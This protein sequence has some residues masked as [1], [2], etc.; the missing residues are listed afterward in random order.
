MTLP[1]V[2]RDFS[3][4]RRGRPAYAVWALDVDVPALRTRSADYC[5]HLA[6]VLL[7]G[8]VRQPHVTIG[9]CGFPVARP[10]WPDDYG[11]EDWL[12]QLDALAGSAPPPFVIE[13]GE[14]DSFTS[15]GY[16]PVVDGVGGID[17]LRALLT[18]VTDDLSYL[19]HVTFGLYRHVMPLNDVLA[20]LAGVAAHP[21]LHLEISRLS[22]M[23]YE[24]A[25]IGG[26]LTRLADFDLAE[27]RLHIREP[28][29]L[30]EL[31]GTAWPPPGF[32]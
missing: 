6:D 7:P 16:F 19:A 4:W 29:R 8:Y 30:R 9:L 3:E 5:A 31:F 21:P 28:A 23:T 14:P 27:R 15:A 12:A 18:P 32:A 26:P 13:L 1:S 24:A 2:Q 20:R 17:K 10:G 22:W 25:V 11:I